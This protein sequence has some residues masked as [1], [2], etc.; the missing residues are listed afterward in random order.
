MRKKLLG[1]AAACIAATVAIPATASPAAAESV[2]AACSVTGASGSGSWEFVNANS[3]KNVNL[4]IKDTAADGHHVAIQLHTVNRSGGSRY[5]TMH[6]LYDGKGSSHTW[7]T[8]ATDNNG[9][10]YAYIEVWVMEG[11]TWLQN[12]QDRSIINPY[13]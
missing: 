9:I 5:W 10:K 1:M 11:S 13:I 8:T 2:G 4:T 6:H 3:L 7:T 12:C